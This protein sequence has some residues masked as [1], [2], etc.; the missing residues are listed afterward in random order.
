MW[1]WWYLGLLL[2]TLAALCGSV[3]TTTSASSNND[4]SNLPMTFNT[5]THK[6]DK[7]KLIITINLFAYRQRE[8]WEDFLANQLKDVRDTGVFNRA[9]QIFVAVSM[10]RSEWQSSALAKVGSSAVSIVRKYIPNPRVQLVGENRF[11]YPAIS[12]MYNRAR[13]MDEFEAESTIFLYFHSKGMFN[14]MDRHLPRDV[15]FLRMMNAVIKPWEVV[16]DG[17]AEFGPRVNKAGYLSSKEGWMWKNFFWVRASY[18]QRLEFP[19]MNRQRFYFEEWISLLALE[20]FNKEWP[21]VDELSFGTALSYDHH[22]SGNADSWSLCNMSL[23][24]GSYGDTDA[25]ACGEE[26]LWLY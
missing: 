6:G 8:N 21:R 20:N 3:L 25:R 4:S 10:D 11:E 16:L 1:R 2:A 26:K 5:T 18:V 14:G 22:Y 24:L 9:Q 19:Q 7:Y 23:P 12:W 17:F 13:Q 15:I